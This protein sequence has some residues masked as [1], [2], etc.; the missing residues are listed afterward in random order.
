MHTI[1]QRQ[2]RT[3]GVLA[4]QV[5]A[6]NCPPLLAKCSNTKVCV[7]G[8]QATIAGARNTNTRPL[9]SFK[10][11]LI[12]CLEL[13]DILISAEHLMSFFFFLEILCFYSYMLSCF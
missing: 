4:S 6:V 12:S 1:Y 9:N 5:V 2:A 3:A 11:Y 7:T 13:L 10:A 8:D